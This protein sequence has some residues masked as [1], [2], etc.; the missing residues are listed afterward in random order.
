M[1]HFL[2]L[3]FLFAHTLLL[4]QMPR[5]TVIGGIQA[6]TTAAAHFPK[7]FEDSQIASLVSTFIQPG[8]D[9]STYSTLEK[10][11]IGFQAQLSGGYR[12]DDF[13]MLGFLGGLGVVQH[14][15]GFHYTDIKNLSYD[16]DVDYWF[17]NVM[18]GL[19]FHP[20]A[21]IAESDETWLAGL[22]LSS[23]VYTGINLTPK[24]IT[25]CHEP[26]ELYGPCEPVETGINEV[27]DGRSDF[28]FAFGLGFEAQFADTGKGIFFESRYHHGTADV[29]DVKDNGFGFANRDKNNIRSLQFSL[30]FLFSF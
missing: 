15:G 11:S 24:S 14:S 12:L 30:G 20:L 16:L 25:Y 17:L 2:V 26:T 6:G 4:A 19:K 27:I 22:Y 10:H 3:C 8:F 23:N 7:V 1:R 13:P 28:G 5:G 21:R 18:L 9:T 29:V